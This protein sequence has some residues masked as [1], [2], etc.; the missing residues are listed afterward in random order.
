MQKV[1][2]SKERTESRKTTTRMINNKSRVTLTTRG[3]CARFP[4][5]AQK[6]IAFQLR[7]GKFLKETGGVF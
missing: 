6:E 5:E 7:R 3:V 2:I 1:Q 4:S